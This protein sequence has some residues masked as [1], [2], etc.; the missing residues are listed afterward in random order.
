M[1]RIRTVVLGCML[2]L[3]GLWPATVH[4]Q[5]NKVEV[6]KS[7]DGI[8]LMVDGRPMMVHGMNWGYIPIGENYAYDL[9]S[10]D[11]AFIKRVLDS[12]MTLLQEMGVNSIRL[13]SDIPPKWVEY[14]YDNY[15]IMTSINHLMG[16]YGFEV[17]GAY[18]PNTNYGDPVIRKAILDD[19]QKSVDRYKDTRGVLMFLLGNE[20]NYGLQWT[21]FNIED[22]PEEVEDG[23]ADQLY[24]F[25]CEAV[26]LVSKNTDHPVGIVNGDL[27]YL[28]LVG[29]YCD[30]LDIFGSNMYRGASAGDAFQRVNDELGLPFMYTEFGS[31]AYNAKTQQEDPSM[32]AKYLK[33]QWREI[34]QQSAGKWGVGNAI[35]GMIFQ[36]SDGWWKYLQETNLDVHDTTAQ[37]STGAYE[38]YEP[39]LNN[40]NE[41]WWGIAA[42]NPSDPTGFYTVT[43][44]TAYY[45]LREAFKLEAYGPNTRPASI[46]AHFNSIS[47]PNLETNYL[48][49]KA[50]QD[51]A[52]LR[53]LRLSGM[54]LVF[55]SSMSQGTENTVRGDELQFGHTESFYTEFSFEH[56]SEVRARLVINGVG[57]VAGNRLD[58]LFYESQRAVSVVSDPGADV[59]E[60][61]VTDRFGIYQADFEIS[62]PRFDVKG[63]YRVGHLGWGYEGDFFNLYPEAYYGPNLDIYNGQAPNGMEFTGKRELQGLKVAIGPQLWWG[64]NPAVIGKYQGNVAG[65]DYAVIH[66]EDLSQRED[67]SSTFAVPAQLNRRSSL[68]LAKN[69][70]SWKIELGG[71]MSGTPRIGDRFLYVRE[72]EGAGYANSDYEVFED[73]I[74]LADTFGGRARATL[75]TPGFLWYGQGSLMGLVADGGYNYTTVVTGWQLK[76]SGRGNHWGLSSGASARFGN[77]EVAPKVLYHQPLIAANPNIEDAFVEGPDLYFEGVRPRNILDDPFTVLENRETL[78]GEFLLVWDPTPGTWWH[79][80]DREYSENAPF[81]AALDIWYQHLPTRRDSNVFTLDTGDVVPFGV[82]PESADEWVATVTGVNNFGAHTKL[83]TSLFVGRK[84]PQNELTRDAGD[85]AYGA[86]LRFWWRNYHIVTRA[87]FDEWG[88]YDFHR[89]FN[90]IYPFQAYFDG[91]W[92]TRPATYEVRGTRIGARAQIRTLDDRS[93]DFVPDLDDPDRMGL[94]W[95]VGIYANIA[96]GGVTHD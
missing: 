28:E 24:K 77:F 79:K 68:L 6:V 17:N 54:R 93:L 55:D 72:A 48:A 20:N 23:R 38:D 16:R 78:A 15:G 32:Q 40:M 63:F 25:W 51:I 65:V 19:I 70:G 58:D 84:Q 18:V 5:A 69:L 31:D 44:R 42:K 10:K 92:G 14:I 37:W 62:Q 56:G 85:L 59:E 81:A 8:R 39:G 47:I 83:A 80:W 13:F 29:R 49:N 33:A 11:E 90:L 74:E 75:T 50:V 86:A 60:T 9:W 2:T 94:E 41:E 1:M 3:L 7:D 96:F 52:V 30:D 57:N 12:E 45:V 95:E 35:G 91:S 27:Q 53:S 34:Y 22:V 66:H 73:E 87:A 43:P 61:A 64:A 76:E 21:S 26:T 46:N 89:D 67:V 88:P 36:W 71:L 82:V 4:A